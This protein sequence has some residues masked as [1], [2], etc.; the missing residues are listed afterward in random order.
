MVQTAD[1]LSGDEVVSLLVSELTADSSFREGGLS[2]GHVERLVGLQGHW[3]PILVRRATG[4]VIDGVHR[5]AAARRLGLDRIEAT[6]FEGNADEALIQFVRRNVYHGLPLTLRERK[7]AARTMLHTHPQ[8]SDRR[9]AELCAISPKTV[10]RLRVTSSEGPADEIPHLDTRSRLGRDNKSHPVDA[11][12]VR[13]R[14]VEALQQQPGASLRTI[15]ASAGVSPETV[16]SVRMNMSSPAPVNLVDNVRELVFAPAE[17]PE[18]PWKQD[19]AFTTSV[20]GDDFVEWFDST[21]IS[22]HDWWSRLDAI[23]I[24]RIYEISDEARRRSEEWT[25]FAQCLEERTRKRT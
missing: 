22:E 9:T 11:A 18:A 16:R 17:P 20:N 10:G 4:D 2:E 1:V 13:S 3:P 14:V 8:W 15:A 24:S 6:Y 19:S 25:R 5:V 23:P 21:T 7:R 12:S